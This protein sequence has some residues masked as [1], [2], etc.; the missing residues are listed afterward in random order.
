[1]LGRGPRLRMFFFSPVLPGGA[2][3]TSNMGEFLVDE[4]GRC[5]ISEGGV[6]LVSSN[7]VAILADDSGRNLVNESGESLLAVFEE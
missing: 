1:M 7:I 6:Y 2:L 3:S 4:A 5:L